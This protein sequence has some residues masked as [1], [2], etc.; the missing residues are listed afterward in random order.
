MG[1][2]HTAALIMWR[3][4]SS[5]EAINASREIQVT[6]AISDSLGLCTAAYT[7]GIYPMEK[8]V[9]MINAQ[10]GTSFTYQELV[11]MGKAMLEEE[12]AFNIKGRPEPE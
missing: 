7:E 8:T 6:A 9:E 3:K 5:S 11:E 4:G 12:R 2:H 10:Y 1:P